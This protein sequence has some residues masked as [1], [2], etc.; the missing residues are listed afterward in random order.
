[1]MKRTLSLLTLPSFSTTVSTV[2]A[3]IS[4]QTSPTISHLICPSPVHFNYLDIDADI[5]I[6]ETTVTDAEGTLIAES[7]DSVDYRVKVNVPVYTLRED[8]S[9]RLTP[10]L[11][12]EP[13]FSACFQ[14]C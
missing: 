7:E 5:T 12:L 4:I 2:K 10:T 1:M 14:S 11:Q 9:Y 3:S 8:V 13:G 6:S